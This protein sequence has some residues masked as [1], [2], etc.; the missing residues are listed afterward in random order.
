MGSG[1]RAIGDM[2]TGDVGAGH[3]S[4]G[5]LVRISASRRGRRIFVGP[6]EAIGAVG[7]LVRC[8]VGQVLRRPAEQRGGAE[9]LAARCDG[10]MAETLAVI[11]IGPSPSHIHRH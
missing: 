9:E 5:V 7:E 1:A 11:A 10:D 6:G 2:R 8:Q 3:A 4:T